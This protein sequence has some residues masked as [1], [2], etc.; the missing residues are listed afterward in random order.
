MF[1]TFDVTTLSEEPHADN[2]STTHEIIVPK[3]SCFFSIQIPHFYQYVKV[4]IHCY[5]E[6]S[7]FSTCNSF[8]LNRVLLPP[9]VN[10]LPILI[11]RRLFTYSLKH[12]SLLTNSMCFQYQ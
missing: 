4:T 9:N 10:S 3:N 1:P 11:V 5:C 2:A 7:V 8:H 12:I 6:N